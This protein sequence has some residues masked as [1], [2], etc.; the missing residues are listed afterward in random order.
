MVVLASGKHTKNIK[1]LQET[2]S[3]LLGKS[4]IFMGHFQ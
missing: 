2:S 4:T 3:F 1:K